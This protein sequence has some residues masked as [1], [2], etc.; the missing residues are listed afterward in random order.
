MTTYLDVMDRYYRAID[1][2]DHDA[3]LALVADD[4]VFAIPER[5]A[6]ETKARHEIHGRSGVAR[7][8]A[9]R[10]TN[11]VHY[12]VAAQVA[13]ERV[14]VEGELHTAGGAVVGCFMAS[15]TFDESGLIS[16]YLVF[17]G[18]PSIESTPHAADSADAGDAAP[19]I[20]LFLQCLGAQE[21]ESAV[22]CF[23][24]E[25]VFSQPS[26]DGT[27]KA[28]VIVRGHVDLLAALRWGGSK[29]GRYLI[30][31]RSQ[32]GSVSLCSGDVV[33]SEGQP[34]GSFLS[35]VTL[36][37]AGRIA[38]YLTFHCDAASRD[39]EEQIRMHGGGRPT[40]R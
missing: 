24:D 1:A 29:P 22:A 18:F 25:A 9:E 8:L 21:Y 14:L 7:W 17:A 32:E 20:D 31:T 27:G 40:H 34:P 19:V 28:R 30:K 39:D 15:A 13:E 10:S 11:V 16:R 23:S 35:S 38:R 3:T 36:D 33:A 26:R 2:G 37:G 12:V 5:D 6:D 4:V